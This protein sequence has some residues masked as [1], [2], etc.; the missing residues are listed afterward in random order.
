MEQSVENFKLALGIISG[1]IS[2]TAITEEQ[3]EIF[4]IYVNA[5]VRPPE[6]VIK[7]I[8]E[9]YITTA[10]IDLSTSIAILNGQMQ[11]L[12]SPSE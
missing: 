1:R 5:G 8:A 12:L 4:G 7:E 11:A 10:L 9:A 3:L 2:R 6:N